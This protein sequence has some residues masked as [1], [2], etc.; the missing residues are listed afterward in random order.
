MFSAWPFRGPSSRKAKPL[1]RATR[2]CK[3]FGS[4]KL[5]L[6]LLEKRELLSLSALGVPV[7]QSVSTSDLPQ[8]DLAAVT[9]VAAPV[10]TVIPG[11]HAT[12][13]VG[14]S[15]TALPDLSGTWRGRLKE[16]NPLGTTISTV[17][18]RI[19]ANP[20]WT[21]VFTGTMIDSE[22]SSEKI[23]GSVKTTG[24][25]VIHGETQGIFILFQL[26]GKLTSAN[27]MA[28]TILIVDKYGG[29]TTGTFTFVRGN[30]P[31]IAATSLKWNTTVGGADLSYRVSGAPLP[32]ATTAQLYWAKGPTRN[33][34]LKPAL[35]SPV[36]IP[37]TSPL[38]QTVNV[39]LAPTRFAGDPPSNATHLVMVVNPADVILESLTTNNVRA[40]SLLSEIK[41]RDATARVSDL[42][43]IAFQYSISKGDAPQAFDFR[44]YLS[45]DLAFSEDDLRLPGRIDN[46]VGRAAGPNGTEKVYANSITLTRKPPISDEARF[47]I[48]VADAED[49]ISEVNEN[50]NAMFVIPIFDNKQYGGFNRASGAFGAGVTESAASEAIGARVSR[51]TAEFNRLLGNPGNNI[52]GVWERNG[53]TFALNQRDGKPFEGD[54]WLVQQPLTVSVLHLVDLINT[55]KAEKRF[56]TGF[57]TITESFDE[58]G[59]HSDKSLHYEGRAID[60]DA[61]DAALGRLAGLATLA[62]FDWINYES[63][64]LHVSQ[65]GERAGVSP[66]VLMAALDFGFQSDPKLITSQARY[67]L[68]HKSLEDAKAAMDSNDK[69]QAQVALQR[70][71][72]QA[73]LG[74]N[75]HE[76]LAGLAKSART[77]EGL[78]RFNANRLAKQWGITLT[79]IATT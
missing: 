75:N 57:L 49:K 18:M 52:R 74:Q 72:N 11:D 16:V 61:A 47:I 39:H 60:F 48:V 63:T 26:T 7:K 59:E 10:S 37:K 44:A 38:N 31:D 20:A 17:T 50:N 12:A 65:Q 30:L 23:T 9:S 34:I 66:E 2:A 15:Y 55:A 25:V 33:D 79:G 68:L 43:K 40:V 70:F 51:G 78:L 35:T 4:R 64:H 36:A 32:Q 29:K 67:D 53:R 41:L 76:I 8:G 28:G 77:K 13:T 73:L 21:S 1:Q 54:D 22:G 58:R 42:S 45:T 69:A 14:A 71:V 24:E 46:P 6:E 62:G 56:R 27:S 19:T 3:S 5:Q